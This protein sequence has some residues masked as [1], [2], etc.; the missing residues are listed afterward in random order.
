MRGIIDN[1]RIVIENKDREIVQL[2]SSISEKEKRIK[3]LEEQMKNM[4]IKDP[5][6]ELSLLKLKRIQKII[7]E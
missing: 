6:I 7:S 2:R 4:T 1:Q 3:D 5:N